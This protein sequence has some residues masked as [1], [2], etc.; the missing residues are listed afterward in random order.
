MKYG[1]FKSWLSFVLF[2]FMGF[3][4]FSQS[5]ATQTITGS[6]VDSTNPQLVITP[7]SITV[8]EGQPI[9]NIV[10]TGFTT[11]YNSS[12][13]SSDYCDEWYNFD[14]SVT[15]GTSDGT[16][17]TGSCDFSG[18]NV[19]GFSNIT[20]TGHDLDAW[21]DTV[22]FDVTFE[23][24]YQTPSCATPSSAGITVSNL[25]ATSADISWA[26][27]SPAPGVGYLYTVSTS[28]TPPAN[29]SGTPTTG[30]TASVGSLTGGIQYYFH[31]QQECST[32]VYS[33]FATRSFIYRLGDNCDSAVNLATLTSPYTGD[34]TGMANDFTNSCAGGNTSPDMVFYLDVPANYTLVIGQTENAYDSENTLFYG[35]SCPGTTQI[36]CYDDSDTTTNTWT[37]TTG[38]LQRIYWVQDGYFDETNFGTFTLAWTLTAPPTCIPP[39][40]VT[41]TPS[42]TT[43]AISWSASASAPTG[44]Y[45]Y[46]LRTSGA[47]GSGSTGLVYSGNTAGLTYNPSGLTGTTAYTFYVR[48]HCSS[49][50]QSTWASSAFTTLLQ[51]DNFANAIAVACGSTTTG[52][53]TNATPDQ[54]NPAVYG[55]AASTTS[56]RNIWYSFTGSGAPQSVTVSLCGSSYDTAI[57]V[58]TGTSGNLTYI[59]GN[60]DSCGNQSELNFTSDGTTTYYIMVR[61]YGDF[62]YGAFTMAVTCAAACTPVASNDDCTS[63]IAA[64]VGTTPLA[65]NNSCATPSTQSYPTCGSQ[66]ASYYDTW[67]S[68]NSGTNTVLEFSTL[69]TSPVVVGYAVYS[70]TCTGLTQVGCSTTGAAGNVT[71]TANTNYLVRA[72]STSPTA[73]G[74]FNL[75]IKVP[76]LPPTG[77][78]ASNVTATTADLSWTAP[79]T[80][81]GSGY[82]YAVTTSSTPPASGTATS[83]TSYAASGLTGGTFYYL[84]VRSV[85]GAGDFSPWVSLTFRYVVNDVCSTAIDLTPLTSPIAGSTIGANDS[86]SPS[87]NSTTTGD[88]GPDTFYKITVPNGFTLVIGLTASDY[89][90][91]HS[92]YYGS[93]SSETSI[94]CTDTEVTNHTWVN[95]TGSTQT[96]YWVQDAW[97]TGSGNYTLAWT[98]TP[99]AISVTSFTPTVI[100]DYARTSTTVTLTGSNF[101]G[102]TSV[103]LG[104][105]SLPFTVV[106]NTT[107][108]V[109]LTTSSVTGTFTVYNAPNGTSATN[110][111]PFN[112]TISPVVEPITGPSTVCTGSTI[113]LA[114][115]SSAGTWSTS[116]SGIA[117]VTGGF[118]TGVAAGTATIS[119]T[120][121]ENGCTTSQSKTVT[122]SP[123]LVSSDPESLNVLV[124]TPAS[125]SVNTSNAQTFQ[126]QVS[127][128]NDSF[129]DLSASAVY[130]NV[131]GSVPT[132]G[133]VTLNI[134]SAT[135]DLDGLYYRVVLTGISP[136]DDYTSVGAMLNVGD[137]GIEPGT[138][139]PVTLCSS[140]TGV[141]QFT[142]Q[143]SGDVNFWNWYVNKNLGDGPEPIN[144]VADGL[145]YDTSVDG[146]LTVSGI[147]FA[148]NGWIFYVEV[149]NTEVEGSVFANATLTVNQAV[150]IGTQ[151]ANQIAC[152]NLSGSKTFSVAATGTGLAYQ[153]Q[154][155]ATGAAGTF[156]N[157]P[158][159]PP[160][161]ITYTA[162]TSTTNALTV[163]YTAATPAGFYYYQVV[164]SGASQCSPVTSNPV[165]LQISLPT[166][167]VTPAAGT[168][169]TPST[170][171]LLTASGAVSY[172]W[173]PA[174]GL[175]ATTGSSV[176][177]NPASTTTYTV[178]GQDSNGC[179]NTKTV[180]VTVAPTPTVTVSATP[181][182]LCSGATTQLDAV[183]P[184]VPTQASNYSFTAVA[185][186]FT[187]L[188]GATATSLGTTDDDVL[189]SAFNIGFSFTFSGT[190]YT[191]I[192]ASSNGQLIF[193]TAGSQSATN[194]LASTTS[195]YRPSI[196][197]LWDDI[198]LTS[199]VKYKL[200]GSAPNR[201]LTV[202]W[203]NVEWN[204]QSNTGVL[205]FQVKLYETTNVVEMVY[206]QESTAYS[207]GTTG[208]ASIGLMGTTSGNF[209]SL[210][211]S[212][213]NPGTSTTTA[214][215][216][217][218]AKPA[219]GQIYR[220]TP[221]V[222]PTY[223]YAWTST[224][225][226]FTSTLKNP[227]ATVT[228]NTTYNVTVTSNS[229]CPVS[230]SVAV[231]TI[232]GATITTQ[233][234]QST[235]T[236][237]QGTGFSITA[238]ASGPGL[239]YQW[240]KDGSPVTGNATATTATLT[241]TNANALPAVSGV[242][243]LLVTPGCGATATTNPV[244]V[245]INP[246]PTV[247]A[248]AAKVYCAGSTAPAIVLAGTPSGVLYDI[249]GGAAIGLANQTGVASIPAFT[250]IAGSATITITPKAN[251]C[252]GTA[253][254]Y[255][256]TVTPQ[257]AA[258]TLTPGTATIC[259]GAIQALTAGNFTTTGTGT[260]GTGTTAP[261]TTAY[262]NPL[263]AYYG[264][265]KHQMLFTAAELNAQGLFAGSS[266]GSLSFYLNNFAANA[267]TNFTI[268]MGTTT[269]TALTGFVSGT[270]T[271]YGPTT[272]TPSATGLATFTLVTPFVWDGTSNIIV[273][274]VHNAGNTGNGS[275]T[276]T[277]T[278][279][280]ATNTVY[281]GAKDSV[282]GGI[283]GFDALVQADYGTSGASNSRP[284]MTFGFTNANAPVWSPTT[285]LYT[286]AAATTAYTGGGRGVVYAKPL[287]TTTYTATSTSGGG[288]TQ[289]ATSVIT[290]N[291][292]YPFYADADH[293][294]YGA[295]SSVS[296]CAVNA[297][298]P[299]SGYSLNNTDCD[300]ADATKWQSTTLYVDA[301][302]D[303]YSSGATATVCY[304]ATVP[305]GYVAAPT[306][307]DC[308]DAVAAINP[309]HAEVLY[310]GVDD[311]CD[312]NLD[313]GFQLL[314]NVITA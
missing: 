18:T 311:N 271:V 248:P 254:T 298:T 13:G 9:Q 289:S 1:L 192:A 142:V 235:I 306:A 40:G 155:S 290:V 65:T 250:T 103:T 225:A 95:T 261:G 81:P 214:T 275:G 124:D 2:L 132:G 115:A 193:G 167:T 170:G 71:L 239:T 265:V 238:A 203:L 281:Y 128:D 267:C 147:T 120:I 17:V 139:A 260:F 21:S 25:T 34:T 211:S 44:G 10:I 78:T 145:T 200:E 276:R 41:S 61:G 229:G 305:A 23:V 86:Y 312:G 251:G 104:S 158:A 151:P 107:I 49:E 310:N 90:S 177:A 56:T 141:A 20:V 53:T 195:S 99:P 89:D 79:A 297:T 197:A 159:T 166:I 148:N 59:A 114:T 208:G 243:T 16:S 140:G 54:S 74:N 233:P 55:V 157:L 109:S 135:A 304:G 47:A 294:G 134:S 85:C 42:A 295:G 126:W 232:S 129:T 190:A 301:D 179:S 178:T 292:N 68:F 282:A 98:L 73:R 152:G 62:S 219:T 228:G 284:N 181:T 64:T 215:N 164:V 277:R 6:G 101:T 43:A 183:T 222:I 165:S 257:A 308:N 92:V 210:T 162:G 12:T 171:V 84:H 202:E 278:S 46:E 50:D 31:L 286:D 184:T 87:C 58:A 116:D 69:G 241:V 314:S 97:Y 220:F 244:T 38:S 274:T 201:V 138:P 121:T 270:S 153:W 149:G 137:I 237:C 22:Y 309:G 39:S 188:T 169:C 83:A 287:T 253:V 48:A 293:D 224:P 8:N 5:V 266:I 187:P 30:T 230:G 80:A 223:T 76:C 209:L 213:T 212:G 111:T 118:V 247:T 36:A 302:F 246:T 3:T 291:H 272:F 256:I 122:V 273:E 172:T 94:V 70:G 259:E 264:G 198:Q 106:N 67:Y 252:T 249:T 60:D 262:P 110:S 258:I 82:E 168:V 27:I 191:Q 26:A 161:G 125:F 28:A 112:I 313:E 236:N 255:G 227:V 14:L 131:S 100:C 269:N 205:S 63:P 123:A 217:I 216:N 91:V 182:S 51:N 173:S 15:G 206:R 300:D 268:R 194:D 245:L 4:G 146:T 207:A 163:N 221:P 29:G 204:Y 136:C 113:T 196:L 72:F 105:E 77:L 75:L 199:G 288:C 285:G 234:A 240:L 175:S 231:T 156:S 307:I 180:T 7:A 108:T 11:H 263:S 283:A 66:F 154:Y 130:S 117:T 296:V 119:Y 57:L 143:T 52:N 303:T 133:V 189:S 299:P 19:T 35:G 33:A 242:Y 226:G 96:V 93:C 176:T 174:T 144:S 160:A 218:T 102:A 127:S 32:G 150:S 24:T 186:T 279:T 280:T 88:V 45:D 37:N 185:G